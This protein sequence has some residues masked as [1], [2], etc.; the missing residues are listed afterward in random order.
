[1]GIPEKIS[2]MGN[3]DFQADELREIVKSEYQLDTGEDWK[4]KISGY[5]PRD[6]LREH[7]VNYQVEFD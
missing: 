7:Y 3:F 1:M 6:L 4:F 5:D 2:S